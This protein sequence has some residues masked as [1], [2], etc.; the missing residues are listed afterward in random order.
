M[1]AETL[2]KAASMMRLRANAATNPGHGWRLG[3]LAGANEVWANRDAAGWDAFMVATT[4]TRLNPNPGVTGHADAAHIAS[5]HPGMALAI[6]DW[7]GSAAEWREANPEDVEDEPDLSEV[8]DPAL[9]VARA[10]LGESA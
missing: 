6:A 4:A 8:D 1:S 7:L 5:W 10:Y 2:R 3:D 9:V